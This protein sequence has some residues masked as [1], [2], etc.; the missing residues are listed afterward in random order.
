MKEKD[1]PNAWGLH[2]MHGNVWEWCRDAWDEQAYSK[3]TDGICDP[4]TINADESASRVVRGGSWSGLAQRCRAA[5]RDW[6]GP[7]FRWG[8]LGLRLSAGQELE[9]AEPQ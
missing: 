3:R 4:E 1:A 9:A 5:I 6:Y 2:D 8:S 7:A